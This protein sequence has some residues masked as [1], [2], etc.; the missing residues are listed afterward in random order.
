MRSIDPTDVPPYFWTIST[1]STLEGGERDRRVGAAEAER[2]RDRRA[3]LHRPR[4]ERDEIQVALR[5]DVDQVR[6]RRRDLVADREHG[7]DR[8]DAAGGT[9]QMSRHR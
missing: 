9:E 8:L 2:I 3:D 6:G 1:T 5:I 7:E 4:N